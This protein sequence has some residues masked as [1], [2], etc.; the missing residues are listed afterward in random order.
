VTAVVHIKRASATGLTVESGT[1]TA[2]SVKLS[3][4]RFSTPQVSVDR[5]TGL[6]TVGAEKVSGSGVT[7][8]PH[9]FTAGT[10]TSQGVTID[11]HE[12]AGGCEREAA[13]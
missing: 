12:G 1:A 8:Q 3:G 13:R 2:G 5:L 9:S 11:L 6:F 10:I 4:A 7:V